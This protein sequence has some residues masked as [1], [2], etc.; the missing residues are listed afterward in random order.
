MSSQ[1]LSTYKDFKTK[2][3]FSWMLDKSYLVKQ[4]TYSLSQYMPSIYAEIVLVL[5][6]NKFLEFK[7][8]DQLKIQDRL[9]DIWFEPE[10]YNIKLKKKFFS[11]PFQFVVVQYE[12]AQ[13]QIADMD[14]EY[15]NI[16]DTKVIL[17]RCIDPTFYK[18][19]LD[20]RVTSYGKVNISSVIKKIAARNGAKIKK[21]VDTDFAFNWLQTQY[22]DY[23][24]IRFLL[25]YSRSTDGED[26]YTFF[27]MNNELYFAPISANKKYPIRFKLDMIKNL[28][29][30]YQTSDM[31]AIIEKYGSKDSLY[32]FH[33]GFSNFESVNPKPMATQSFISNK[34]YN[35]QHTGVATRYID[36]IIE[37]K[38]LQEIYISNLRH[39][40]H[41]FSRL[42]TFKAEAIPEITPISC[43]EIISESNGKTKEL[44]GI[45]YVASVKYTFGMTNTYPDLPYMDLYL[46]SELDSKGLA[47]PEGRPIE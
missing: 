16:N 15:E 13:C 25:P 29:G 43:I 6:S 46:C 19:T 40:I 10:L 2:I 37:E 1:V 35:K 27:M 23:E 18:M 42:L 30:T 22:T 14:L 34:S 8:I 26:M 7:N 5:D 12:F 21:L 3:R 9:I 17:L 38:T 45:Y 47:N 33:H 28:D 39:R 32:S 24:M 36:S 31:K 41:T 11:G 44:D 4:F 20:Q